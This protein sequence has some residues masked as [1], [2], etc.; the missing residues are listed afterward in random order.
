L[1]VEVELFTRENL[2]GWTNGVVLGS[3]EPSALGSSSETV[4]GRDSD[5]ISVL[6]DLG[7]PS[8]A[9]LRSIGGSSSSRSKVSLVVEGCHEK[10]VVKLDEVTSSRGRGDVNRSCGS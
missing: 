10:I 8:R 7:V 4:H 6:G 5:S 9:P 2:E 1:H 3:K